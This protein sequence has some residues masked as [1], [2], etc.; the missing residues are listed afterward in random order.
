MKWLLR[1]LAVSMLL[2]ALAVGLAVQRQPLVQ[3]LTPLTPEDIARAMELLRQQ[4]PRRPGLPD[5]RSAVLAER[6]VDLLLREASRRGLPV[7][8]RLAFQ[9]G[10]ATVRA[11]A[12]LG[13]LGLWLN[14]EADLRP[15]TGLPRVERL[16]VGD[17]PLP[18]WLGDRVLRAAVARLADTD[19][20]RLVLGTLREVEFGNQ[21]V[22]FN[23]VWRPELADRLRTNLL[24]PPEQARLKVHAE[25]LAALTAA[26][27]TATVSLAEL[28]P[29]MFTLAESRSAAGEDAVLENRAALLALAF[30]ANGRGLGVL[31]PAATGWAQPRLL[32]VTLAGRDDFPQHFL[33]SALLALEGGGRLAD[34][35]GVYKEVRDSRGGSG[36]SF[37]DMAAN[38]A[39]TRFGLLAAQRPRAVQAAV[40]R[41]VV[42]A[43]FMPDV[44]DLPEFMT[45]T[46]FLRR[47][48]GVGAPAF[49]EAMARIES[50]LDALPLLQLGR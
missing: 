24:P 45:E 7:A 37:N 14:T 15:G 40:A 17:L 10:R 31:V 26:H 47:Y 42:E 3:P 29:P 50:R 20:G 22:R 34:A 16:R 21:E 8:A 30:L 1:A 36:F 33:I 39:G 5:L 6:D 2:L 46:E 19:S 49:E 12:P 41:G 9:P 32:R 27:P 23:Y 43:D 11:S 18:G 48:G 35:I 38:R 28:L 44:A 13:M 4:D 25:R